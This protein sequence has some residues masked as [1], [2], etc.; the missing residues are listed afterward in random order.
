MG[1]GLELDG[2]RVGDRAGDEDGDGNWV[3]AEV[4]DGDGL[5]MGMGNGL[6]TGMGLELK[7]HCAPNTIKTSFHHHNNTPSG[8]NVQVLFPKG[9]L[10]SAGW[11][12]RGQGADVPGCSAQTDLLV[13]FL[14]P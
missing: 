1:M 6:G 12:L 3:G 14:F 9:N 8:Q 5:G 11:E 13:T 2:D 4:G 10:V 7:G